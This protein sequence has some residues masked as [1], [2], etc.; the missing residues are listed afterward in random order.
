MLYKT[1]RIIFQQWKKRKRKRKRNKL[2]NSINNIDK[3]NNILGV[4]ESKLFV[5]VINSLDQFE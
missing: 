4:G 5:M 2:G 1:F 3:N